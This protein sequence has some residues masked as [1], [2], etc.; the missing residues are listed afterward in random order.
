MIGN[1]RNEMVTAC[2]AVSLHAAFFFGFLRITLP[3][4]PVVYELSLAGAVGFGA[5][6]MLLDFGFHPGRIWERIYRNI[7]SCKLLSIGLALY[8]LLDTIGL[9]YSPNLS[10]A[11]D[12]TVQIALKLLLALLMLY[13]IDHRLQVKHLLDNFILVGIVSAIGTYLLYFF[14]RPVYLQRLTAVRD[15]NQ[16]SLVVLLSFICLFV[17]LF[18]MK[19]HAVWGRYAVLFLYAALCFPIFLLSGSRRTLMIAPCVLVFLLVFAAVQAQVRRKPAMLRGVLLSLLCFLFA[20][21]TTFLFAS[22]FPSQAGERARGPQGGSSQQGGM[23]EGSTLEDTI[24]TMMDGK[25]VAKRTIIWSIAADGIR[26]MTPVQWIFGRGS[27][28]DLYLYDR[29]SYPALEQAYPTAEKQPGWMNPH[30]FFFSDLLTGGLLKLSVS[31]FILVM[32]FLTVC[33]LFRINPNGVLY[34]LPLGLCFFNSGISG[35]FGLFYDKIFWF[36]IILLIGAV[37]AWKRD[38]VPDDGSV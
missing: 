9:L 2:F 22:W 17:R 37:A 23:S 13:Y 30:S 32:A 10:V 4:V 1:R 7:G 5:A 14:S 34:F 3:A 33:R 35:K 38:R 29:Q 27:G 15:Y 16:F 21:L 19:T 36:F 6:K 20:C 28:Y 31:L 8:I 12:K 26:E 11:V 18:Y 24:E 25:A